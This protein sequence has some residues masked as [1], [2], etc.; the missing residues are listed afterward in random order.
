MIK[1]LIL[2]NPKVH[3]ISF[4]GISPY[5]T[6]A[7]QRELKEAASE[8][9][10]IA[11]LYFSSVTIYTPELLKK[12]FPEIAYTVKDY[13]F[14]YE[15]KCKQAGIKANRVWLSLGCLMWKPAFMLKIS[16]QLK[17]PNDILVY[18]DINLAKYPHYKDNLK[19]GESFF[20]ELLKNHSIALFQDRARPL[21]TD[22]KLWLLKKYFNKEPDCG[23]FMQGFWGGILAV[24]NDEM[25]KSFLKEWHKI[26]NLDHCAPLPDVSKKER[27]KN[28]GYHSQ[29]QSTLGVLYY[30]YQEK[31]SNAIRVILT[32][33]RRLIYRIRWFNPWLLFSLNRLRKK[34]ALLNQRRKNSE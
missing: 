11:I 12:D 9:K 28:F 29:E 32:P 3:L 6:K 7:D 30:A 20:K 15:D 4:V 13:N 1:N 14:Q 24:K 16:E 23:A 33:H 21:K 18:Q 25:G 31:F 26:S 34:I 10:R 19:A 27:L 8:F 2:E 17:D 22:C 5:L